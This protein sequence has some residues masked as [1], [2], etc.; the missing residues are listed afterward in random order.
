M[1]QFFWLPLR[2]L[3]I[4]IHVARDH[5]AGAPYVTPFSSSV[6][7][8]RRRRR[9]PSSRTSLARLHQMP[10]SAVESLSHAAMHLDLATGRHLCSSRKDPQ[11]RAGKQQLKP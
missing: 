9:S 11:A 7:R 6:F 3:S 8:S 10:S 2:S 5:V 1:F 4:A